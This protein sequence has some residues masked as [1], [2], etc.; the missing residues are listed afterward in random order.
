LQSLAAMA[1]PALPAGRFAGITVMPEFIQTEAIE[2]VLDNIA[3][4][5]GAT[6]VATSPYVMTIADEATGSREPPIDAGAGKARL[7]DRPLWGKRELFVKTAPSYSPD[8]RLYRG[9]RYQPAPVNELTR[10]Q[11]PLIGEFVRAAR[12]RRLKVY[13]QIQAAI[14]P[15]YRVQFGGPAEEDQ[16]RLPDGRIPTRRVANNGSL[17]SREISAYAQAL[18]RDLCQAYQEI[19]G[20]RVDWPEYPPYFLDGVFLDFSPAAQA[21]ASRLGFSFE[22]MRREAGDLYRLLHGDL[23]DAH[24]RRWQKPDWNRFAALEWNRLKAA[25]TDELLSGFRAALTAAGGKEKELMPNAFPPPFSFASGM[26]FA[27]AARHSAGI[28]VKLYTMHWPMM[29]R[30]YGDA[31]REAN[32]SIDERLLVRALA[33]WFDIADDGGFERLADYRYPEP[34][35]PHPAGPRAQ[36]RKIREAQ[37]AAGTVPVLALAHG[38]GPVADFRNR[39]RV[40]YEAAGQRVWVNRYGY[41]SDAKLDAMGAICR[42]G[43]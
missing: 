31:L 39:L 1:M 6:A 30:F 3:G 17:A 37:A 12:A 22:R 24:L 21:A 25:L 27:R 38:Y 41:L 20:I 32:P 19:D 4:R 23:T 10:R 43:R 18:I 5:A 9:L 13:L 40:A 15:G 29:L 11:G 36:A 33:A 35:E 26:D 14:P 34:E 8:L 2:R 42:A 16:P 28:S 7:L